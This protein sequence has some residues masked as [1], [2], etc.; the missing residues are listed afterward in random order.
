MYNSSLEQFL[1][2]FNY[3]L[4]Q[5]SPEANSPQKRV[6]FIIKVMTRHVHKYVNRGLFEKD[7]ITFL[8]MICFKILITAKK[9]TGAD[10]GAFLK[11]G[12]GEDIKTARP[13]PQGNQFNF[14]DEK[15]W[16]NIIAFSK[17]TFGESS[18]PNFKELPDLIQK[19]QPGWLQYFDKN[20]PENFPI[21]DLAER[22]S[23]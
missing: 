2:L 11:A 16:L 13:K 3:S 15:S 14:L 23:Q 18:I 7:K 4:A 12:A 9:L 17:H 20:D 21:P 19:N 5:K 6:E 22:M 8:L 1:D 10:V